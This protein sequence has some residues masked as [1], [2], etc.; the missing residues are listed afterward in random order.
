M[1]EAGTW[2]NG[3]EAGRGGVLA[4]FGRV[5][6]AEWTKLRTVRSTAWA[7]LAV[8]A[9]TVALSAFVCSALDTDAGALSDNDSVMPSVAGVYVS[10]IAVVALAVLAITGEY[11][12]GMIR[13]TF[14]ATPGRGRVLAA[15][16]VVLG[17]VTLAVGVAASVASFLVGQPI[18]AGNGFVATPLSDPGA[19]RAVLGSGLYLAVLALFGLGVGAILR[20]PAGA[21]SAVLGLLFGPLIVAMFL[22]GH[23]QKLAL[24]YGPMTAGLAVQMTK[25]TGIIVGTVPV[26]PWTGFALFCAYTSATLLAAFWL[27]T[28]RDA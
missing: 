8:V 5:L 11:A 15:K 21:V 2:T 22:P 19:L 16:A 13:T 26:A 27:T 20:R 4:G 1:A 9:L 14:L 24:D 18:L 28:H 23:L 3:V 6:H 25:P 12:T 17:A 7:L 10:Q